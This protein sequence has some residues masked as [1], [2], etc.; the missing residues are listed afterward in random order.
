MFG[1]IGGEV[2]YR[3]FNKRLSLA[4]SADRVKQREY[5][6]RFGFRNYKV[7]TG[8][9]KLFYELPGNVLFNSSV[10]QYLAGDKGITI[11][12]SRKFKS[13]F[14]LGIFATKTDLSSEEFGEGTFD[15]GF[16]FSIP[17]ELFY[18]DYR[19]GNISFGLHP[20]TKDGGAFLNEHNALYGIIGESSRPFLLDDW[21]DLL[22]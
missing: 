9:V 6:Q 7:N 18:T 16:Y 17:T 20:L 11:D 21:N 13:G 5:K 4:L 19:P 3:P 12:L 8:H 10:G 14:S 1:G 22:D 2:L 15:K